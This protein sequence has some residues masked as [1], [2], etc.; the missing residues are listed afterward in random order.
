MDVFR[1]DCHPSVVA[2]ELTE[3]KAANEFVQWFTSN[4]TFDGF[5]TAKDFDYYYSSL[6]SSLPTDAAFIDLVQKTWDLV[7][8]KA[9]STDPER[10]CPADYAAVR[11]TKKIILLISFSLYLSISLSHLSLSPSRSIYLSIIV[12]FCR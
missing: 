2:G 10:P 8:D 9:F 12:L 3:K 1:A 5:V 7:P 6:S 4:K 11:R